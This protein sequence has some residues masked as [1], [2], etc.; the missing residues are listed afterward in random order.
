MLLLIVIGIS[1]LVVMLESVEDIREEYGRAL[2][3]AE[4]VITI[5]F[6]AEYVMRLACAPRPGRYARSFFGIVDL[7]AILPTYFM[8]L[9]PGAQR[10]TVIRALRLLR[11]FRVF[12]LGHMLSEASGL[13]QAIWARRSPRR[14][15]CS[16]TA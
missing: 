16:A 1:A 7:L 3:I 6:T 10:L 5:L 9:F 8:V 11:A 2:V 13:R 15:W 14:S 12:K 4:W